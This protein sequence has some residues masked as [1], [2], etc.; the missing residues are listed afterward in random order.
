MAPPVGMLTVLGVAWRVSSSA[1]AVASWPTWGC[2][3]PASH[4]SG[5]G[6]VED[7]PDLHT[8]PGLA[9]A[10]HVALAI[11]PVGDRPERQPLGPQLGHDG[12]QVGIGEVGTGLVGDR[13]G[14]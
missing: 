6:P 11:E 7:A 13:G 10:C 3:S 2:T 14:L 5:S 4:Q 12:H 8:V 9:R 1:L